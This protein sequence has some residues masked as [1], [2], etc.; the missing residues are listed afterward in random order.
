MADRTA[1]GAGAAG[2]G[3]AAGSVRRDIALWTASLV[4]Q[5]PELSEELAPGRRSPAGA[6]P[7]VPPPGRDESIRDSTPEALA[8]LKPSFRR[9]GGTVT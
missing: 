5:F 6:A 1:S 9:E 8:K 2:G 7:A 4:R 3:R